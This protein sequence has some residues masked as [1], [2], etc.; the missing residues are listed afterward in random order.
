MEKEE[1]K[2]NP[3]ISSAVGFFIFEKD[4]EGPILLRRAAQDDNLEKVKIFL[5]NLFLDVNTPTQF[6][7]ASLHGIAYDCHRNW[8]QTLIFYSRHLYKC[9]NTRWIFPIAFSFCQ[10]IYR[11]CQNL[12]STFRYSC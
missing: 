2:K 9:S 12:I 3:I 7:L 8:S 10:S 1:L 5:Y 4:N 6:G 11:M